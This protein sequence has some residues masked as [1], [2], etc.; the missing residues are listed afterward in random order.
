MKKFWLNTAVM[1]ILTLFFLGSGRV[2]ARSIASPGPRTFL[3]PDITPEPSAAQPRAPEGVAAT[4]GFLVDHTNTDLAIPEIWIAEAKSSLHIAYEHTSH[5][6]QLVT[7]MNALANYPDFGD[8][9]AWVDN[10]HGDIDHLSLDDYGIPNGPNDLSTGDA[11][12][13]GDG[14][15]DWAESTY[16]YLVDP[17]HYH[18]NVIL[19]SWCNIA[20]HDIPRYLDS[21][22]WLIGLF[23]EGGT[24]ERAAEHPVKFVFI[25]G[26]ANGG[27]EN[28]SSDSQ[29]QL[30]RAHVNSHNRILY[31][32]A[33]M[34]N[35]DPDENYFLDKRVED[36]LDYDSTP[37]YDSGSKDANWAVEYLDR[38]DDSE[39]DRLTTGDNVPGYSGAG[40]CAHSNGPNNRA[41]LNCVLKGRAA[42]HLFARLAGWDGN[43]VSDHLMAAPDDE[44]LHVSWELTGTLPVSATWRISYT[45]PAGDHASPIENISQ[46]DRGYTLTGLTNGASYDVTLNAML[47]GSPYLTATVTA[48]PSANPVFLPLVTTSI[49]AA[50]TLRLSWNHASG[51]TR[52]QVWRSASPYFDLSGPDA[53][54]VDA[55]PWRYDDANAVGDPA[56]NH[57]Y[58]IVGVKNDGSVT[59]SGRVGEFDFALRPGAVTRVFVDGPG[60]DVDTGMDLLMSS[61]WATRNGG[62]HASFQLEGLPG[63]IQ[64]ALLK[65]DLSSLPANGVCTSATLHLYH[66][67]SPE[68]EGMNTGHVYSVA[69][70]NWPWI[71]GTGDIDIARQGEPCW[72]A[73]EADGSEGVQTPWAGSAGASTASV[74]YEPT[75]IG[76][77][78]FNANA[79]KGAEILIDLDC[80]RVQGWFGANNNNYGIILVAD[81]NVHSVHV[82]SAENATAA[83][84]P[85]LEVTYQTP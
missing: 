3:A 48:S 62:Q 61:S 44:A 32:F 60:G 57:Y 76:S 84:R 71:E 11:D 67:Y 18:V 51:Y 22:E 54:W 41:R 74:D 13:D 8:K 34:E 53:G 21:M 73:R 47:N 72:N 46:D 40:S 43:P 50:D 58:R 70:A 6:S 15:D 26:H 82:G 69:A 85:K 52:Y 83:Y 81:D 42:W 38:H 27:G 30:I 37:P 14:I 78:S 68:G 16:D 45:G 28:D 49:P 17:N 5:G 35:Y 12:S 80:N 33:D 59:I 56:E 66:D 20:G 7:G 24:H 75:A 19:W 2:M 36:D 77:W 9:Y 10:T 23:D 29:N 4:A 64:H 39:L 63:T 55:A 1:I 31:D 79:A 25:T 65:F